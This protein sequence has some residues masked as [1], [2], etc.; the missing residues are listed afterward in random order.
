M[1]GRLYIDGS[2]AWSSW[3]VL[4]ADGGYEGIAA[5]PPLKSYESNDWHEEDGI[6]ADL[7]APVLDRKEA[8]VQF[9]TL[10]GMADY[11]SFI[12]ALE[13][14]VYHEVNFAELGRT[15]KLRVVS[16]SNLT[17]CGK[18]WR[19]SVKFCDDFPLSDYEYAAPSGG[20]AYASGQGC[21]LDGKSLSQYGVTLLRD[22]T[23]GVALPA[24][25]KANLSRSVAEE[26]GLEYDGEGAVTRKQK[27]IRLSCLMRNSTLSGLWGCWDALLYDLTQAGARTLSIP[28]AG[29]VVECAYKSCEVSEVLPRAAWIKFT[30]RLTVVSYAV[31][32]DLLLCTEAEDEIHTEADEGILVA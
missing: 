11:Y 29:Q 7:S 25:I 19:F 16:Y 5:M 24:S 31:G 23:A 8:S 32:S 26:A 22:T 14:G 12:D 20:I 18:V 10:G 17:L 1:T 27:E 28:G 9:L 13:D 4:V 3:R 6:E 15:Y 21:R 2:D 30:L